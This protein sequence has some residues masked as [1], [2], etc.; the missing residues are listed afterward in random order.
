MDPTPASPARLLQHNAPWLLILL[1]LAVL[2]GPTFYDLSRTLWA[3][4]QQGHGPI[5]LAVSCWL[6][7]RS[8]PQLDNTQTSP[9]WPALAWPLLLLGSVTY[10]LGRSQGIW[11]FEM[12]SL[13]VLVAGSVL[14]VRGPR[15]L[16]AIKFALFFMLF[17]IPLPG[18]LVDSMTQPMKAGVSWASELLMQAAGYPVGRTG[19]TL[20][21]GQYQLLVADACAG[22]HTLFVL[23]ALGLLYLNIVRH[24]SAFRNIALAILIVPISFCANVIRVIV[25]CLITY[26]FG[27]EAGQGFLHDFAGMVLFLS[28]LA[29]T[30][31]IDGVLRLGQQLWQRRRSV[32][33]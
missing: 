20:Q 5:V 17:M 10:A 29:L 16:F 18:A 2:F 31:W 3:G 25:L 14:L 24:T 4:D 28:A 8:W 7:W 26:H 12:G 21:V 19:V 23:E 15:Q 27:D 6:L 22:L 30:I 1:G 11:L 32:A 33:A 9:P 13:I